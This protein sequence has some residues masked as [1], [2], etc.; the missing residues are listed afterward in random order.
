[1]IIPSN[2]KSKTKHSY[3]SR[4]DYKKMALSFLD[5]V[6]QESRFI[7]LWYDKPLYGKIN[8][9][10]QAV[11]NLPESTL[12][13]VN[14]DADTLF[15]I[16]FVAHA[17]NDMKKY[18]ID[19]VAKGQMGSNIGTI[20]GLNPKRAWTSSLSAFEDH[21]V[22]MRNLFISEYLVPNEKHVN[23]IYDTITQY[24]RFV[25][26][27]AKDFPM[28][29][30][31]FIVSNLCP[32]QSTGLI[33]ELQEFKHGDDIENLKIIDSYLF[34]KFTS[35]ANRYGFYI[36]KNAPYSLVANLGSTPMKNYMKF[37]DIE[38]PNNY[39]REYCYPAYR[40][41][42]QKM[43][44]F[45]YESHKEFV[46][47]RPFRRETAVSK[48]GLRKK[49]KV[50]NFLTAESMN[51]IMSM[52]DWYRMCIY[53]KSEELGIT[54]HPTEVNRLMEKVSYFRMKEAALRDD[55]GATD[56]G[57]AAGH[58]TPEQQEERTRSRR[59]ERQMWFDRTH[60]EIDNYFK[61]RDPRV[62]LLLK[63]DKSSN[64]S[65]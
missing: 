29:F 4:L 1:M 41:D 48:R 39:F 21:M 36:N 8:L 34:N 33:I 38:S 32:I 18:F 17:F 44:E 28:T 16:D 55:A 13:Q 45:I 42:M 56:A 58:L 60:K 61:K 15:A 49:T 65:Y 23:N 31:N 64:L 47:A 25:R 3:D 46:L 40:L 26:A 59:R 9:E 57:W 24:K 62:N 22:M 6:R 10:G 7:D 63:Q 11:Y 14:S 43:K 27:H 54:V 20:D 37:Y 30:G 2:N 50:R 5:A 51:T 19:A 52:D 53:V 12:G 35:I